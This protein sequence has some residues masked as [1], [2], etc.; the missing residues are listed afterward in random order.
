MRR[1]DDWSRGAQ[2]SQPEP[3]GKY[4]EPRMPWPEVVALLQKYTVWKS[5][6]IPGY[7]TLRGLN[8]GELFA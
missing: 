8:S 5:R 6:A 3:G 4:N 7:I 2:Y 1:S